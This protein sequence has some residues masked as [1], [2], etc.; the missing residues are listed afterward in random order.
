LTL[1]KAKYSITTSK[2]YE[3]LIFQSTH[4]PEKYWSDVANKHDSIAWFRKFDEVLDKSNPPFYRWFKGGIMNTCFNC[5]DVHVQQGRGDQ[6]ALIWDSP[7][8]N[9]VKKYTYKELLEEVRKFAK[10]LKSIGVHK[11]DRIV[12]YMPMI[13]EAVI[14]MLACAR[15]GAVHSVVF[16]GFASDQLAS[17]INHAKPKVVITANFS[18]EPTHQVAYKPLLDNAIELSEHKPSA[19]I[20]YNREITSNMKVAPAKMNAGFDHDWKTLMKNVHVDHKKDDTIEH[21]SALDPLYIL[22]TSGTTGNPKGVVRDNGGHAV[23]LKWSLSNIFDIQP[24]DVWWAASDIGWVVGHSYIV[25]GPL[26]QGATSIMYEGKPVGTPDAG[27]FWRVLS[28]H[29]AKSMFAAPTA[30]RAIKRDDPEGK[31]I[32]KYDLSAMKSL[33]LAGE[34]A[35]PDTVMWTQALMKEK[36]VI[37][38]WWQTETGWPIAANSPVYGLFDIKPGS[39]CKPVPGYDVRVF[40]PDGHSLPHDHLGD[41]V[42]KLPLP[43]GCLTSLYQNDEG[44]KEAYFNKYPGYYRTGDA[45]MIDA[46]GYLHIL[47]R[48]DD[49]IKVAGHRLATG[50]IEEALSAHPNV[51]ECAVIAVE[52]SIKGEV[53]L[54]LVVLKSGVTKDH[55]TI[56]AECVERVREHVGPV[57]A[58]RKCIVV[59]HLPK[60]RSGKILRATLRQIANSHE[61]KVPPTID[62]ITVLDHV[63]ERLNTVGHATKHKNKKH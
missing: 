49:I 9:S 35:D 59:N 48:V 20:I 42:I 47:S 23:A 10:I 53:P 27:A 46:D 36:P 56:V 17:R 21:L 30:M 44:C 11:G 62:N 4:N 24:G 38:H 28:Q 29:K 31:L 25:Y 14:S 40:D 22:Y 58:F 37:D 54:G 12:I 43:P 63:I 19:C 16:G 7:V 34:R 33:F 15:I 6:E 60:T 61:Y 1:R 50:S 3:D 55:N 32:A 51:A 39:C 45:G 41:V 18:I 13:P 2:K 57:A 5:L 8:S 26:L 52:D